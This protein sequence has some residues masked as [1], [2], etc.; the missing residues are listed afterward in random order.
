MQKNERERERLISSRADI[1][2]K[3]RNATEDLLI[4][5]GE[6]LKRQ[7]NIHKATVRK[8][9]AHVHAG[10]L[11]FVFCCRK[12]ALLAARSSIAGKIMHRFVFLLLILF[13]VGI[14]GKFIQFG[15]TPT[16]ICLFSFSAIPAS[17]R[18][19]VHFH[20]ITDSLTT[21]SVFSVDPGWNTDSDHS[22]HVEWHPSPSTSKGKASR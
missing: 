22:D 16:K 5:L 9:N 17:L 18:K 14:A 15:F 3:I 13:L 11:T 19:W 6:L 2:K 12:S 8:E 1:Q 7:I 20:K 10:F 4:R 21:P